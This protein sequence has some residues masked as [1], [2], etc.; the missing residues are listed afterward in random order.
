MVAELSEMLGI[1]TNHPPDGRIVIRLVGALDAAG[2]SR[3]MDETDHIDPHVD[4]EIALH[5]EDVTFIDAAGVGAL[6]YLDA[7]VRARRGELV[8]GSPSRRVKAVL[9]AVG[10]ADRILG[11]GQS[12]VDPDASVSGRRGLAGAV[13]EKIWR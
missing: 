7:F 10:L 11:D 9:E 6:C 13:D 8:I 4:D 5:L 1:V 2:A 3:L 12:A